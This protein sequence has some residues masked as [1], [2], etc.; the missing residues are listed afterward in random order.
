MKSS[1]YYVV[2]W[3]KPTRTSDWLIG[4]LKDRWWIELFC[5]IS[6]KYNWLD[7]TMAIKKFDTGD[8]IR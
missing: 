5:E 1:L 8:K 6:G 7:Q 4:I 3:L 2:D